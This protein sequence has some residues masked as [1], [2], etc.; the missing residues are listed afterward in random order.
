[1]W[2]APESGPPA[3]P[4]DP[5]EIS[6]GPG[7]APCASSQAQLPNSPSFTA[8]STSTQAGAFSPFVAKVTRENGTQRLTHLHVTLPPGLIGKL[9]GVGECSAAQIAAAE[10]TSGAQQKQS[11]SCPASSELG[12]VNVGAGSGT[13]YYV[14]GH[15]YLAGPYKGAPL[16][17]VIITP[18]T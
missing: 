8:G 13:P 6:G 17:A 11:P 5:W 15:I 14:Q 16:S 2:S 9:A 12:T 1:P 7:G 18:A 4:K 3:T 10:K